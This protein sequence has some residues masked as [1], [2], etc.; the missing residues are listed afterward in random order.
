MIK[1]DIAHKQFI[2]HLRGLDRSPSTVVA[3]SKD[4]EQLTEHL[5]KQGLELV[6]EIETDHLK[7]FMDKLAEQGYTNKSI[8]RKTNSTKTFFRY[9]ITEEVIELNAADD[10]KHPKVEIKAPRILSR[11]EYGALRD[12]ARDDARTFAI[13]EVLLQTGLRI[14]ELS[15]IKM[16]HVT[17]GETK[18]DGTLHIPERRRHSMRSV[19]LNEAAVKAIVSYLEEKPEVESS[20][21]LF[22]TKTGNPLLVRNIRATLTRF[23]D[24]AGVEEATVN[25]LRHTFVAH[26]LAQG[27]SLQTVS[28]IAGHKRVSTTERYLEYIEKKTED[29]KTELG[30]L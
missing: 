1:L 27:T 12:A 6:H 30:I 4:I 25:D 29:E 18:T 21:H 14:S 13:I 2:D 8:S 15:S 23:F 11:L 24:K 3:Y 5:F 26:H 16:D 20:E 17:I 7:S 9:L 22:I 10:L 19:P 28:K